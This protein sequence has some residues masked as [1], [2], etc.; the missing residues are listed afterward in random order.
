[1]GACHTQSCI[2]VCQCVSLGNAR[3]GKGML[4]FEENIESLSELRLIGS[5]LVKSRKPKLDLFQDA[6]DP[7]VDPAVL[8][9]HSQVCFDGQSSSSAAVVA[10]EVVLQEFA[11]MQERDGGNTVTLEFMARVAADFVNDPPPLRV[12]CNGNPLA[13]FLRLSPSYTVFRFE[14]PADEPV[15]SVALGLDFDESGGSMMYGD[16]DGRGQADGYPADENDA[17]KNRTAALCEACWSG[18]LRTLPEGWCYQADMAVEFMAHG[19]SGS[20]LIDVYVNG[21]TVPCQADLPL[22]G[23]AAEGTSE[24]QVVIDKTFGVRVAGAEF[25]P[26]WA[27]GMG[28]LEIKYSEASSGGS[29]LFRVFSLAVDPYEFSRLFTYHTTIVFISS[30]SVDLQALLVISEAAAEQQRSGLPWVQLLEWGLQACY[31]A[32]SAASALANTETWPNPIYGFS[33]NDM[34]TSWQKHLRPKILL[35]LFIGASHRCVT[36]WHGVLPRQD[37]VDRDYRHYYR[38]VALELLLI[39]PWTTAILHAKWLAGMIPRR[40]TLPRQQR[41]NFNSTDDLYCSSRQAFQRNQSLPVSALQLTPDFWQKLV[42]PVKPGPPGQLMASHITSFGDSENSLNNPSCRAACVGSAMRPPLWDASQVDHHGCKARFDVALEATLRN[43]LG[44]ASALGVSNARASTEQPVL[45]ARLSILFTHAFFTIALAEH[46]HKIRTRSFGVAWAVVTWCIMVLAFAFSHSDGVAPQLH[47]LHKEGTVQTDKCKCADCAD[48]QVMQLPILARELSFSMMVCHTLAILGVWSASSNLPWR[49]RVGGHFVR[50]EDRGIGLQDRTAWYSAFIPSFPNDLVSQILV[51]PGPMCF[52]FTAGAVVTVRLAAPKRSRIPSDKYHAR[53]FLNQVAPKLILGSMDLVPALRSGWQCSQCDG[54]TAEAINVIIYVSIMSIPGFHGSATALNFNAF[55]KNWNAKKERRYVALLVGMMAFWGLF[56][57][58]VTDCGLD[59]E[60]G[61]LQEAMLVFSAALPTLVSLLAGLVNR[62]GDGLC[63]WLAAM[64]PTSLLMLSVASEFRTCIELVRFETVDTPKAKTALRP[65]FH[66]C[67]IVVYEGA[68]LWAYRSRAVM[69]PIEIALFLTH[70]IQLL[71]MGMPVGVKAGSWVGGLALIFLMSMIREMATLYVA[72]QGGS[73]SPQIPWFNLPGHLISLMVGAGMTMSTFAQVNFFWLL[74]AH[75]WAS[76]F[77][78]GIS[79]EGVE[80]AEDTQSL[81]AG[82]L[83]VVLFAFLGVHVYSM[84][85]W[86]FWLLKAKTDRETNQEMLQRAESKNAVMAFT[87]SN[88]TT[89]DLV[90][91]NLARSGTTAQLALPQR[92]LA[93]QSAAASFVRSHTIRDMSASLQRNA[94]LPCAVPLKAEDF[95][96]ISDQDQTLNSLFPDDLSPQAAVTLPAEKGTAAGAQE[97]LRVGGSSKEDEEA[98]N[99][100]LRRSDSKLKQEEHALAPTSPRP[101]ALLQTER[102]LRDVLMEMPGMALD[103]S[104]EQETIL[105]VDGTDSPRHSLKLR[106]GLGARCQHLSPLLQWQYC[107]L[108]QQ[109][110]MTN[111]VHYSYGLA[112]PVSTQL[113]VTISVQELPGKMPVEGLMAALDEPQ[114]DFRIA[115]ALDVDKLASTMKSSGF[116]EEN[117]DSPDDGGD[118]S[119]AAAAA[120]AAAAREEE[121]QKRKEAEEAARRLEAERLELQRLE[122]AEQKR[123][124]EEAERLEAERLEQQRLEKERLQKQ[125][126]KEQQEKEAA[127]RLDQERLEKERLE[128]DHLAR[129]AAEAAEAAELAAQKAKR[130]E[131]AKKDLQSAIASRSRE[132]LETLLHDREEVDLLS[133]EDIEAATTVLHDVIEE[134]NRKAAEH[135]LEVACSHGDTCELE[136]AI[137]RAKKVGV[138]E[139]IIGAA[140]ARLQQINLD[141]A[142]REAAVKRLRE[143]ITRIQGAIASGDGL[144]DQITALEE[145]IDQSSNAGVAQAEIKV[146]EEL[147]FLLQSKLRREEAMKDISVALSDQNVEAVKTAIVEARNAGMPQHELVRSEDLLQNLVDAIELAN[148]KEKLLTKRIENAKASKTK[149]EQAA[150]SKEVEAM[151]AEGG[152]VAVLKDAIKEAKEMKLVKKGAIAKAEAVLPEIIT[153]LK[154]ILEVKKVQ[155]KRLAQDRLKAEMDFANTLQFVSSAVLAQLREAIG[156]AKAYAADNVKEAELLLAKLEKENERLTAEALLAIE[157]AFSSRSPEMISSSIMQCCSMMM[158]E[159]VED[160]KIRLRKL[161]TEDIEAARDEH[162]KEQ[163]LILVG[164]LAQYLEILRNLGDKQLRQFHNE[165]QELKGALRV[166]CRIRPMNKRERENHD[167]IAVEMLDPFTVALDKTATDRQVFAYDTI[168]PESSTQA[169]VFAE[170]RS[171]V[172]SVIDGYNVTVFT[173]GQTGAGKTWTL[174]GSGSEPGI[175]PRICEEIFN[176]VQRDSEKLDFSVKASMIELYCAELRDLLNKAKDHPKLE[177]KGYRQA[178]GSV[179]QRLEGM[180]E[181]PVA[182]SS[183]LAQVVSQGLGSRKVRATAMNADSSRSHFLL[184]IT[185]EMTDKETGRSRT[186]KISIVDLAGSE[187]LGKSGVSGE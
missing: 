14:C 46:S 8:V 125:L 176:F 178:D 19:V 81:G 40:N 167:T 111:R 72:L 56:T 149:A 144:K 31:K 114:E 158:E 37:V 128:M 29:L 127:R 121:E 138:P 64:I 173:Y 105:Q 79:D 77:V 39:D 13:H 96:T 38:L 109:Q 49:F 94:T 187:R 119:E 70:L 69:L 21:L 118:D 103:E 23:A 123:K 143:L 83:T 10:A 50:L 175:S 65:P 17:A 122:A 148:N 155:E 160:A 84:F 124:R 76:C 60:S 3:D 91:S 57:A 22:S 117:G 154:R 134:E 179:G 98:Q 30:R 166:F 108:M 42:V 12:L 174:Y 32:Q 44:D 47:G 78:G 162:D 41:A 146:A 92:G 27:M 157:S 7:D 165:L 115:A 90:R 142:Q 180:T 75:H 129:L 100:A 58:F 183:D 63:L 169:E 86:L 102:L 71:F 67:D 9:R 18:S 33:N 147:L 73:F 181:V 88:T 52:L 54:V 95:E 182:S 87:S 164:T 116:A 24:P 113:S 45:K 177:F 11:K 4:L 97:Q 15:E 132:L 163:R 68:D 184:I 2:K 25:C 59:S 168:F 140:E 99:D 130:Q 131:A 101:W 137:A 1:M 34:P 159:V 151:L 110:T 82:L 35:H 141:R 20:E 48:R 104:V 153:D 185:M 171:M 172:Q 135:S 170:C 5:A 107:A 136:G 126:E 156:A 120:L 26:G 106:G 186:G 74:Y 36:Q 145:G 61:K 16:P 62:S 53:F 66:A 161:V 55:L 85:S 139:H 43:S 89:L 80:V 152:V 150:S 112:G 28:R 51:G 6:A 133:D 93:P